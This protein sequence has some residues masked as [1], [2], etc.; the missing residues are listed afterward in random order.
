MH[1]FI[2]LPVWLNIIV[3]LISAGAV[4]MA[5]TRLSYFVEVISRKTGIGQAVVGVI[6]LGGITSLPEIIVVT[7]YLG[8]VAILFT[9][10]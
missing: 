10:R 5:G 1:V 2:G 8:G 7:A 9:L 4:W 3:F 6:L